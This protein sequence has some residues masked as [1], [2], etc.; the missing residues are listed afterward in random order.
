MSYSDLLHSLGF[1]RDPFA[2]TNADEEELLE[3]Y[4]IEPPFFKAVYGDIHAPKSA[5][6]YA[7]RGGGKTAL[8]RRIELSARTEAFLSVTY[9]SFPTAGLKLKDISLEYHLRNIV[10]VLLVAILS[11]ATTSGVEKLKTS[12]RH[13]LYVL[14]KE[15]LTQL[16]RAELKEAL[17]SVTHISD[18][19]KDVW[20]KL[21]GP[22]SAGLNVAMGLWGFKAPEISKFEID[23]AKAGSFEEQIKFLVSIVPNFGFASAYVLV[24]KIDENPLT[25]GATAS[26]AFIRPLLSD[27]G[28]LETTGMAFKL[29]LW[30]RIE[31]DAREFSRP[32]RIK[33]YTLKWTAPQLKTML[34]RRLAA[35]SDK[36]VLSLAA[37]TELG[38][39]ADLDELVVSLSG[40]SP[41]NIIRICKAIFDQQSELNSQSRVVSERA[42]FAGIEDIAAAIAAETVPENILRDLKKLKRADFTLTNVYADVFRISQGAGTQKVQSWQDSGAVIKIGS[43]QEKRGSRPRN[44]YA[45]SSPVVLKH[46]FSDTNALDFSEKKMRRC[47][48]GQLVLRDWDRSRNQ[49]CHSCEHNFSEI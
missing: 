12:D 13:F 21:T 22:I 39:S 5:V 37:I 15:H 48:C 41:R 35:H 29:F 46:I 17:S 24:D 27:L 40:G 3:D 23:K 34:S 32:D 11:E 38:R 33:T 20:N 28:I 8:K 36:K 16:S 18:K 1:E 6:V 42:V 31:T 2:K 10:R 7:P 30:D 4:F 49:S 44:V 9:N 14:A 19:A 25:G 26:L 47:E 45:I 43:R